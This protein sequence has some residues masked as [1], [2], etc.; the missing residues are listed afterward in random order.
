MLPRARR[1]SRRPQFK[2]LVHYPR[3]GKSNC[4]QKGNLIVAN[5]EPTVVVKVPEPAGDRPVDL[6]PCDAR[7]VGRVP[8]RP[9]AFVVE[10]PAC[11]VYV[12]DEKVKP[13]IAVRISPKRNLR[14]SAHSSR[15]PYP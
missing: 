4:R 5:H 14:T 3:G 12:R 15:P 13:A 6:P 2:R 1:S 10:E 9:V 11:A 7:L 8:E